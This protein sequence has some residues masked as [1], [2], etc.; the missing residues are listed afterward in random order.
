MNKKASVHRT[1][2][3]TKSGICGWRGLR[4]LKHADPIG[5]LPKGSPS[6]EPLS[7]RRE[8]VASAK[9]RNWKVSLP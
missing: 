4:S 7:T 8:Y 6:R 9:E 1:Y 3:R 2:V 5:D